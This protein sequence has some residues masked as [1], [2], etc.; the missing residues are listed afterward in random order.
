MSKLNN[1]VV[2][3]K[4]DYVI[5]VNFDSYT[6]K[7]PNCVYYNGTKLPFDNEFAGATV[8]NS[9]YVVMNYLEKIKTEVKNAEITGEEVNSIYYVT[10]PDI[11]YDKISKGTYK[12]WVLKKS[13]VNSEREINQLELQ[14]WTQFLNLYK[15]IFEYVE[16]KR[17]SLYNIKKPKF[18]VNHIRYVNNVITQCWELIAQHENKKL[19]AILDAVEA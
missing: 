5:A 6:D 11:L 18:N 14:L 9:L 1:V 10:I 2:V 12:N 13:Y 7:R 19:E 15:E 17:L 8:V 3:G 16:F 4:K